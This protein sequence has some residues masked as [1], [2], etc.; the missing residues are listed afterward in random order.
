MTRAGWLGL[1]VLSAGCATAPP[2]TQPALDVV[3][4]DGWTARADTGAAP[5]FGWWTDFGDS[6]LDEAVR[7]ALEQNYDLQA[8]AARLEQAAADAR[9]AA[10]GLQP[11][12][13]AGLNGSRRKQNFI[14]FPI[15]GSEDRVLSTVSTNYAQAWSLVYFCWNY[16]N[17][18]YAPVMRNY[19]KACRRGLGL[20]EAFEASFAKLDMTVFTQQ[21]KT[22]ILGLKDLRE[23]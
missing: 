9:I 2:Y 18:K 4:P 3:T 19:Y 6:G 11:T 14:G 12:V 1:A 5:A 20:K 15:P 7:T 13:Q 17:G 23:E 10:A 16:R 21:W 22:Y 8:A